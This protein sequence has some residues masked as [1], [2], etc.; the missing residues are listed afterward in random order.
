MDP[1][2]FQKV[3][4]ALSD[5]QRFAILERIAN[6]TEQ[7]KAAARVAVGKSGDAAPSDRSTEVKVRAKVGEGRGKFEESTPANGSPALGE[8]ACMRLVEEFP[9]TQATISHHLKE[10][11]AAGLVTLRRV[12]KCHYFTANAPIIELYR[13]E[14]AR[15]LLGL[16]TR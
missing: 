9:V 14:L 8:Y 1:T 13:S 16:H 2:Q 15:R 3:S 11:Q 4:K 12:G 10:L 5:P 7:A 6:P